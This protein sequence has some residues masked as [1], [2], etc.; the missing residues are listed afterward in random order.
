MTKGLVIAEL[1][2]PTCTDRGTRTPTN[3][4]VTRT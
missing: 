3:I 4:I 1:E 2:V